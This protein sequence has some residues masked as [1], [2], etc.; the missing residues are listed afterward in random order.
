[1]VLGPSETWQSATGVW[2]TYS[3]PAA[4]GASLARTAARWLRKQLI[5][6]HPRAE[7]LGNLNMPRASGNSIWSLAYSK[8]SMHQTEV[9]SCC[10]VGHALA[11]FPERPP[12]HA[13]QQPDIHLKS[14]AGWCRCTDGSQHAQR[15]TGCHNCMPRGLDYIEAGP[16]HGTD[17]VAH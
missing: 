4:R 8:S 14:L 7:A 5:L 10:C 15:P 17:N 12:V 1:M 6:D 2:H 16:V 13:W 9:L 3:C 11:H